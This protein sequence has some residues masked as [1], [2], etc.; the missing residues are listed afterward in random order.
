MFVF[1]IILCLIM[2]ITLTFF[3][4]YH[5]SMI[6]DNMTTNEK[7]KRSD[8]LSYIEDEIKKL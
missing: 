3:L 4:L 6:K 8:Y 5:F 1:I 2:G 7:I